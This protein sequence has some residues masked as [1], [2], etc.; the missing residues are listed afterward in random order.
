MSFAGN[1]QQD[2]GNLYT[3]Q[4]NT[5]PTINLNGVRGTA[6]FNGG[7]ITL[8]QDSN[9]SAML[10]FNGTLQIQGN[11]TLNMRIDGSDPMTNDYILADACE[12]SAAMPL[13][14]SPTSPTN[15]RRTAD[16]C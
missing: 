9:T 6:V 10:E 11:T 5:S 13:S 3:T 7:S 8:G 12:R 15:S 1:Y 4:S 14:P 16:G 2:D